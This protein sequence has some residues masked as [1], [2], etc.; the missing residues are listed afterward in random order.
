MGMAK[1]QIDY[2]RIDAEGKTVPG[3]V[4]CRAS[5]IGIAIDAAIEELKADDDTV[6]YV[7]V[8]AKTVA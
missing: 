2:Q 5:H 3:S 7:I 6:S 8:A 1:F 4:I